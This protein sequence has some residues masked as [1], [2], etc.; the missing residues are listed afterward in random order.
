[1]IGGAPLFSPDGK[2]LAYFAQRGQKWVAVLDGKEGVEYDGIGKGASFS[3][4]SQRLAYAAWKGAKRL[5]V[6]DGQEGPE[7]DGG[8]VP[9]FSADSRHLAYFA[10][11]GDTWRVFLDGKPVSPVHDGPGAGPMFCS[12]GALEW[13]AYEQEGGFSHFTRFMCRRL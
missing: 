11:T 9:V 4:D 5:V 10:Q 13:I 1:M 6:V 2:R 12:N 8:T 3:P 7:T